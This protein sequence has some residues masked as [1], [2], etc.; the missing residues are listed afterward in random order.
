LVEWSTLL[1]FTV[2]LVSHYILEEKSTS[3]TYIVPWREKNKRNYRLVSF[4]QSVHHPTCNF[5]RRLRDNNLEL[6]VDNE[7]GVFQEVCYICSELRI[8]II[9]LIWRRSRLHF[10]NEFLNLARAKVTI[11]YGACD[12]ILPCFSL[13][14][15][16]PLLS[17][18]H[19]FCNE[20]VHHAKLY[21]LSQ[22]TI[23]AAKRRKQ[24]CW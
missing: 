15:L 4:F 12:I 2:V 7:L 23:L 11:L 3:F 1:S 17:I 19:C 9:L 8:I 16:L 10:R 5:N 24:F 13:Q 22:F 18:S 20:C 21:F 14:L 6:L